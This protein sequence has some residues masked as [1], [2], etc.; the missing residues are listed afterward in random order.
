MSADFRPRP[1]ASRPRQPHRVRRTALATAASL[2]ALAFGAT[3][4]H[5]DVGS[6][7]FDANGNAAAGGSFFQ[8]NQGYRNVGLGAE[9]LPNLNT[10]VDNVGIGDH[11]LFGN[12]YGDDNIAIGSSAMVGP[13]NGTQPN[14]NIGIGSQALSGITN[15][16]NNVA[17][18]FQALSANTT[19]AENIAAGTNALNDNT[20]GDQ[21]LAFG[22]GALTNAVSAD[23]NVAAGYHALFANTTGQ[24]NTALGDRTLNSNTTGDNNL[25]AGAGAGASLTTGSDN[26]D[27]ASPGKAGEAGTIRIGTQ[28]QTR[29]FLAGVSGTAISRPA[30][31]V[32][33]NA[34]GQLGT[35]RAATRR[36][37][38]GAKVSE[39]ALSR[40]QAKVTRLAQQNRRQEKE[41]RALRAGD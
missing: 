25:A 33:I 38:G 18:G 24:D 7:Y 22:R 14:N 1:P 30:Q 23:E 6:V 26:I 13:A 8:P 5:A 3:A 19:G 36:S 9:V 15:G 29:A 35:A 21:N 32:L 16:A 20:T 34:S 11:A 28:L 2:A 39:S 12:F 17:T 41:L 4:S 27:I 40:L 37:G 10:A 31:P